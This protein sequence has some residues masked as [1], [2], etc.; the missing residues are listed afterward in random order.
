MK[1]LIVFSTKSLSVILLLIS[2]SF[3]L[4]SV[5]YGFLR[6]D[7]DKDEKIGLPEAVHALRAVAGFHVTGP[8]N[9]LNVPG[10]FAT[11]QEAID[12][13]SEGDTI[14]VAAATYTGTV[15][16]VNKVIRLQGAGRDITILNVGGTG[17]KDDPDVV[18]IERSQ[19]EITG[20]QIRNGHRGIYAVHSGVLCNNNRLENNFR[21]LSATSNSAVEIANTLSKYNNCDG[22]FV[23]GSS[24][25]YIHNCEFSYNSR[26]GVVFWL[27]ASGNIHDNTISNNVRRGLN[28]TSGSSVYLVGNTVSSNGENGVGI[29]YSSSVF[30]EGGN[31]VSSNTSRGIMLGWTS[32]LFMGSTSG[33]IEQNGADTI[34]QNGLSGILVAYGSDACIYEGNISNNDRGIEV[35][36]SCSAYLKGCDISSNVNDGMYLHNNALVRFDTPKVTIN[37][38]GGC[39]LFYFAGTTAWYTNNITFGIGDNANAGGNLC[40]PDCPQ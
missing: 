22:S 4:S 23:Y 8:T 33:A 7:I 28:V 12:A 39:G 13:A 21:G 10:D 3:A 17:T 16:I 9:T 20:F 1:K 26:D 34:S 6:G 24:S 15:S 18:K 5:S 27:G 30:F 35:L 38:N 40:C 29:Y 32:S 14:N 11:N 36:P 25:A 31:T 19:V 2:F 37:S